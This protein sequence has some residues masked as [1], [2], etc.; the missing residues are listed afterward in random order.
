[1]IK[2]V[3]VQTS[4]RKRVA[5]VRG[6]VVLVMTTLL[7]LAGV[8]VASQAQAAG[9][10]AASCSG[11]DPVGKGCTATS[12]TTGS[13]TW[14]TVTNRY[15]AGCRANWVR[16]QLSAAAVNAG[17]KMWLNIQTTDSAGRNVYMCWPTGGVSN[18]GN[19]YE[20][21][22][23]ASPVGGSGVIYSDMVDGTN[24]TYADMLV[25]DA[26]GT[27]LVAEYRANQ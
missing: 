27:T 5:R 17:Y 11:W 26:S 19:T 4:Q 1:M 3:R 14:G 24:I 13:G 21:C 6:A 15:A 20:S 10:Y 22:Y 25:F 2:E 8:G 7:A 9:C 16:G 23:G 18:H 12:T